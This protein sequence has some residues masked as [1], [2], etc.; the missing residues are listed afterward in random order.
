MNTDSRQM[1]F[2]SSSIFCTARNSATTKNI[3][4]MTGKSV[5]QRG[6]DR[7][8]VFTSDRTAI[9]VSSV[10]RAQRNKGRVNR[11]GQAQVDVLITALSVHRTYHYV[12]HIVHRKAELPLVFV[13]TRHDIECYFESKGLI[14]ASL[15][16]AH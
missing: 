16:N 4:G 12:Q 6:T 8:V 2:C 9:S 1:R 15:K 3:A 11:E 5:N 14:G 13:T 10:H 7:V